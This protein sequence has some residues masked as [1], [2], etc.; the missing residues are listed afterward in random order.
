LTA[1][2]AE[3]G[4]EARVKVLVLDDLRA[5]VRARD[6]TLASAMP[7]RSWRWTTWNH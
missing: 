4:E 2:D 7:S 6:T 3:A 5:L 1:A